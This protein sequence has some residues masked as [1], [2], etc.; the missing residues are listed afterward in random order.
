MEGVDSLSTSA[1]GLVGSPAAQHSGLIALIGLIIVG[2]LVPVAS[3]LTLYWLTR[4]QAHFAWYMLHLAI[5]VLG[6]LAVVILAVEGV[7]DAAAAAILS[8]IVAYS[9]GASGNQSGRADAGPGGRPAAAPSVIP[10]PRAQVNTQCTTGT[11]RFRGASPPYHLAW[12]PF[13]GESLPPGLQF[14]GDTG[15]VSG[16]PTQAGTY[17]FVVRAATPGGAPVGS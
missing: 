12:A 2:I 10:L 14:D 9:V 6:I 8:S 11:V 17:T 15:V 4:T 13:P 1:A 5:G 16:T 7:L 3:G